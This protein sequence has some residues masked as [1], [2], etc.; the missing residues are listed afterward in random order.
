MA[1]S[2]H[3]PLTREEVN[4]LY[5][6]SRAV[7]ESA[8]EA[9]ADSRALKARIEAAALSRSAAAARPARLPKDSRTR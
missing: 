2:A 8:R 9:C 5:D 4:A 6:W 7:R 1:R 3:R